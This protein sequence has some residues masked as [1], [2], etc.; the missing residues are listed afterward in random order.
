MLEKILV[1]G[2]LAGLGAGFIMFAGM[3]IWNGLKVTLGCKEDKTG[4]QD[5]SKEEA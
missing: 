2:C 1:V 5:S 4:E 3:V